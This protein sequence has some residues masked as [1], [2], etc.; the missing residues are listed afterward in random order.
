MW[1]L[2]KQSYREVPSSYLWLRRHINTTLLL[3]GLQSSKKYMTGV[4]QMHK[5]YAAPEGAGSKK[6]LLKLINIFKKSVYR[7][8][9]YY[10]L[11]FL[12]YFFLTRLVK[13]SDITWEFEEFKDI[14]LL[15][16][17]STDSEQTLL[18][19]KIL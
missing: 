6:C 11:A 1:Q 3:A 17:W 5:E 16:L 2:Q 18:N 8:Y 9:I 13:L 14:L 19:L 10:C 15:H 12:L 7:V 4:L